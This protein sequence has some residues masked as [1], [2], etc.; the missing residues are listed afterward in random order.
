MKL[1]STRAPGDSVLILIYNNDHLRHLDSYCKLSAKN[2][3]LR[4]AST[5]GEKIL[6]AIT[7]YMADSLD[8]RENLTY[9]ALLKR[10]IDLRYDDCDRPVQIGTY[11]GKILGYNYIDLEMEEVMSRIVVHS[12]RADFK[13]KSYE[14]KS[15]KNL[16]IYLIDVN[17]RASLLGNS[18]PVSIVNSDGLS[19]TDLAEFVNP[20]ML[21]C[22]PHEKVD[23]NLLRLDAKLYAY[24]DYGMH[25]QGAMLV[26][27]GTMDGKTY[28]YPFRINRGIYSGGAEVS[29]I[30]RGKT[31]T[32]DITLHSLGSEC[33]YRE[34][35]PTELSVDLIR[36]EWE[37]EDGRTVFFS[38]H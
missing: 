17:S 12:I 27:E 11:I 14:G 26:I 33:P 10:N 24:P 13:G 6:V 35:G 5:P 1:S 7:G 30:E 32:F 37:V 4:T 15:L 9:D 34:I 2:G 25:S 8:Y 28:Y 38:K 22:Y 23:T 18:N 16:R 19:E 36:E 31:Y 21:F 20:D 29:G 3:I